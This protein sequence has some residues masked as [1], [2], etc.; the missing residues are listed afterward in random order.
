MKARLTVV[1]EW[2]Y[3]KYDDTTWAVF[4][5]QPTLHGGSSWHGGEHLLLALGVSAA[6]QQANPSGTA[7]LGV[8]TT[9][10]G[11]AAWAF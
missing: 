10:E 7:K 5:I 4:T 8:F 11:S 9:F 6:L 3:I 1:D 2:L